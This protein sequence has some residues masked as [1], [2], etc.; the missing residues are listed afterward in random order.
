MRHGDITS[1]SLTPEFYEGAAY[2]ER[3]VSAMRSLLV[4]KGILG[5]DEIETRLAEVRARFATGAD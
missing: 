1:E 2:Y 3:W 4:E 5:E